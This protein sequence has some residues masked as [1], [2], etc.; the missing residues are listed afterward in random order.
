MPDRAVLGAG[1]RAPS[2]HNAQPWRFRKLGDGA[3]DLPYW[4]EDKLLC[5][6][7]DRAGLLQRKRKGAPGTTL[8]D[9]RD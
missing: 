8:L 9:G 7:D 3:Y 5:D 6:P 4:H 1:L 2:P